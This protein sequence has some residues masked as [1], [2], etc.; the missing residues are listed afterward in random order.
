MAP[1][2]HL[3]AF[4]QRPIGDDDLDSK[5]GHIA[6]LVSGKAKS[7]LLEFKSI[8]IKTDWRGIATSMLADDESL[9]RFVPD[10]AELGVLM[11][12]HHWG[13]FFRRV[14]DPCQRRR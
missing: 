6:Q 12:L 7:F 9:L 10:L 13:G 11:T 14:F 3:L 1:L 5:G 4:M 2:D 8:L